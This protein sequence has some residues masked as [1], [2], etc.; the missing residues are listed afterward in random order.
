MESEGSS[1]CSQECTEDLYRE[2][3]NQCLTAAMMTFFWVWT[4]RQIPTF[5][6]NIVY[7]FSVLRWGQYVSPKR[8]R[9][10]TTPH[11]VTTQ[12]NVVKLMQSAPFI[13]I[14]LRSLLILHSHTRPCLPS[15]IFLSCVVTKMLYEFIIFTIRSTYPAHLIFLELVT[16]IPVPVATRSEAYD[17]IAW[18]WARGFE[19]RLRHGCLPSFCIDRGLCD[20]LITRPYESLNNKIEKPLVYEAAKVLSRTVEPR[21]RGRSP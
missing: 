6:R 2:K 7:S 5:R 8:W 12:N 11:G 17:L 18:R 19:S 1:P 15:G 20:G 14:F 3:N 21:G 9:L 16:L 10:L 13:P 4:R